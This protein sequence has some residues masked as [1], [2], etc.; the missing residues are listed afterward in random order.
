MH[1]NVATNSLQK[2]S[3]VLSRFVP[4]KQLEQLINILPHSLIMNNTVNT[5]F[6]FINAW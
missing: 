5:K 3:K 1:C 6:L 4:N 2:A